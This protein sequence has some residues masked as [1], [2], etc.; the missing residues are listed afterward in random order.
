MKRKGIKITYN[1]PVVLTFVLIC[2]VVTL[3][4]QLT[5]GRSTKLLFETYHSSL[6]DPLTYPRFITYI[7]GHSGWDHFMGNVMYLLL[8][9]PMLEE[10]YG[11]K[12]LLQ[13]IAIT[14]IVTSLIN[15]IFFPHVALLG[16]S[17]IVFAFIL[18]TS[19][20]GFR[21]GELPLTFILVAVLFIG[22]QIL[23]GVFVKDNISN[24][25]HIVGGI[26]GAVVGYNL[27]KGHRR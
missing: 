13:I 17:G 22:Q 9:G 11:S 16:A 20:T 14:A 7:F 1:A 10:K 5:G 3:I 2:F 12:K 23:Q 18:L 21:N 27:N 4:G 8:L 15:Y 19:F 24:M 26:V 6:L 25:A